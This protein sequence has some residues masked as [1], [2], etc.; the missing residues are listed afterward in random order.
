MSD[1]FSFPAAEPLP[2]RIVDSAAV[3]SALR[4][5]VSAAEPAVVF[6]SLAAVCVP[7]LCDGCRIDIEE[8]GAE[9]YRI[10]YPRHELSVV[11]GGVPEDPARAGGSLDQR[12]GEQWVSTPFL[13]DAV[14]GVPGYRGVVVHCWREGYRPRAVEA[15][16]ARSAVD[17]AI[18]L[19]SQQRLTD[20]MRALQRM[21]TNLQGALGSNREIGTALGILMATHRISLPEAFDLLRTASQHSHRKLR[22]VAE[23]VV[24]TGAL[25]QRLT[26]RGS[27]QSPVSVPGPQTATAAPR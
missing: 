12:V 14:A 6:T 18:A 24:F 5:M 19:I 20:Q 1:N 22:N 8:D 26:A 13:V 23:E 7:A 27:A 9:M 21:A 15:A 10:S 3:L 25:D 17:H 4:Q 11:G 16:L 2:D